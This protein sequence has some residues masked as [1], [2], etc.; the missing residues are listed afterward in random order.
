MEKKETHDEEND[1]DILEVFED[2]A[3][4]DEDED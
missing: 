1:N 4:D 3:L 2:G